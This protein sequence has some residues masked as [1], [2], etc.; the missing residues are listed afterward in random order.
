MFAAFTIDVTS[1]SVMEV[2][3]RATLALRDAD[4]S[5]TELSEGEGCRVEDL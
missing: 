3:M 1:R 5:G 4:G 2:R